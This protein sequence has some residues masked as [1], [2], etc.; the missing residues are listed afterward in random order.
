VEVAVSIPAV[1]PSESSTDSTG[2]SSLSAACPPSASAAG[3][4]SSVNPRAGQESG[5]PKA[6]FITE[7]EEFLGNLI[8][9]QQIVDVARE[10]F[11]GNPVPPAMEQ[12]LLFDKEYCQAHETFLKERSAR[13]A[14]LIETHYDPHAP[15]LSQ[16]YDTDAD[17]EIMTE[18]EQ[19]FWHNHHQGHVQE[20]EEV[21]PH[22]RPSYVF[23]PSN[24]D[25]ELRHKFHMF[26][27]TKPA[28]GKM[29]PLS[30]KSVNVYYHSIFST[31]RPHSFIQFVKQSYGEDTKL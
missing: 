19:Y 18:N 27:E 3:S 5:N 8:I 22:I 23:K 28:R 31:S 29:N 2:P 30:K 1:A 11:P 6:D 9:P 13:L 15:H 26:L 14:S 7:K 25:E 17:K 20:P 10:W 16:P 21:I 12:K 24:S 4:D